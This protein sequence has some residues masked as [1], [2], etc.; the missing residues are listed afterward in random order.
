MGKSTLSMSTGC[1]SIEVNNI[2]TY[3]R[4]KYL[5]K[6]LEYQCTVKMEVI[7]TKQAS[8]KCSIPASER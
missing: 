1:G 5:S 8:S 6:S 7:G 3:E 4:Y 2:H